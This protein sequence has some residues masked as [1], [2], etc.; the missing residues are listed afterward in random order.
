MNQDELTEQIAAML[1]TGVR[2]AIERREVTPLRQA[3]IGAYRLRMGGQALDDEAAICNHVFPS[4]VE[5]T[6]RLSLRIV[7]TDREKASV[8]LKG[9]V[10]QVLNRLSV[11]QP[12]QRGPDSSW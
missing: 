4:D 11:V 9:A 12:A 3:A 6:A 10:E 8:L 1:R 7:E 5:Q 2:E